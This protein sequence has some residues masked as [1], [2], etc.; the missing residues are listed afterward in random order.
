MGAYLQGFTINR[1]FAIPYLR[2]IHTL[3]AML[4]FLEGILKLTDCK[5]AERLGSN[6]K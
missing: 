4:M 3:E 5:V 2:Y 6:F 1:F